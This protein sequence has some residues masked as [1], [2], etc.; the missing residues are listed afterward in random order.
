MIISVPRDEDYGF[1][2]P[3]GGHTDL[4]LRLIIL[5]ASTERFTVEL[6]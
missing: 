4:A 5:L 2:S 1:F 3:I 6:A